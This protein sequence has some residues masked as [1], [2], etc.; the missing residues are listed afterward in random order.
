MS[1]V[2]HGEDRIHDV[3]PLLISHGCVN[4]SGMSN[5]P[6]TSS[7]CMRTALRF[8]LMQ[9]WLIVHAIATWPVLVEHMIPPTDD[10]FGCR[11]NC[12]S[13]VVAIVV[14]RICKVAGL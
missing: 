2:F 13:T 1:V 5:F 7:L 8:T 11:P 10:V 9:R 4:Q 12:A 14:A 3:V 6:Q